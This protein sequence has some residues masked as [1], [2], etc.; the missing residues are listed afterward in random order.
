[1]EPP[2]LRLR[3]YGFDA[4]FAVS[5]SF[6]CRLVSIPQVQGEARGR[7][8]ARR[9]LH[10]HPLDPI[11]LRSFIVS[12]D[13]PRSC[14]A[15]TGPAGRT[16]VQALAMRWRA[17]R[18]QCTVVHSTTY[19]GRSGGRC[20]A[21]CRGGRSCL[22]AD[23]SHQTQLACGS[24]IFAKGAEKTGKKQK[25]ELLKPPLNLRGSFT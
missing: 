5:S 17:R 11:P 19:S 18:R 16:A 14:E 23:A 15:Q 24:N 9:G 13:A 2:N 12:R 7:P 25:F 1:L 3:I 6:F 4:S 21:G 22:V 8:C 20:A 10:R